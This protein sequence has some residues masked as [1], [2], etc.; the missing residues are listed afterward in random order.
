MSDSMVERVARAIATEHGDDYDEI[1]QNKKEWVVSRGTFQGRFRDVNEPYQIDYYGMAEAA[2][3]A[4]E[5]WLSDNGF[6]VVP[7]EPTREMGLKGGWEIGH[8]MKQENQIQRA[9]QC[10]QAMTDAA[11]IWQR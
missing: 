8:T 2:I 10:W 4:H 5:A 3:K 1:P 7:R 11:P 6:V 9:R